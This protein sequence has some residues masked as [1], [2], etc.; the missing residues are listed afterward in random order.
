[1]LV[2]RAGGFVAP[3]LALYLVG[4]GESVEAAGAIVALVGFGSLGAGPVGGALAD[5]L[6]RRPT[7][8]LATFAGAASMLALALARTPVAF[9]ASALAL[10]FFGEM[11]RPPAMAMLSDVVPPADRPRAFGLIYWAINLGFAFA[12]VVGGLLAQ[13]SFAALFIGDA[14]TTLAFGAL[15]LIL[16]RESRPEHPAGPREKQASLATLVRPYRHG[17]FVVFALVT[18]LSALVMQQGSTTMPVDLARHGVSAETYGLLI[19]SNGVVIVLLQPF[20]GALTGRMPRGRALALGALVLGAGFGLNGVARGS[21]PLYA[22]A[23]FVWTLG[24][25]AMAGIGPSVVADFAPP[26]LRGSYQGAYQL[27]WSAASFIAPIAGSQL[28]GRLGS[29]AT[30]GM[31]VV[32]G[33]AAAA[34]FT[35]VVPEPQ[36]RAKPA[37]AVTALASPPAPPP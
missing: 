14:A 19:A 29:A 1:M 26:H 12:G 23:V 22:V 31:C 21:V 17:A 35:A 15:I 9:G 32:A 7:L 36:R 3:F 11:Y 34:G 5:R 10:G 2:N 37:D 8:A 24:E 20:A 25:I 18:L 28:L 27:V 13:R 16:A 4:R 30:W 6:G 33:T